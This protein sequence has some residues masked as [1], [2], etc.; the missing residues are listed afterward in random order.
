MFELIN[1]FHT[2]VTNPIY[3]PRQSKITKHY[4]AVF[5][6]EHVGRFDVAVEQIVVVEVLDSAQEVPEDILYV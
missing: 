6:D 4:R 1:N 3:W 5:V 2:L